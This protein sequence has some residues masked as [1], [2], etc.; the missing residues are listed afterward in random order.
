MGKKAIK[1]QSFKLFIVINISNKLV[2]FFLLKL[3]LFDAF[4]REE[5]KLA[6]CRSLYA[7]MRLM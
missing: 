2:A 7:S 6:N 3:H 1:S 5:A 4:Y